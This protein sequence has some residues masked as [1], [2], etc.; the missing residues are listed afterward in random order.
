MHEASTRTSGT[1]RRKSW[2]QSSH[3]S[4]SL[5]AYQESKGHSSQ[6]RPLLRALS[7]P[8]CSFPCFGRRAPALSKTLVT[9]HREPYLKDWVLGRVQADAYLSKVVEPP[10]CLVYQHNTSFKGGAQGRGYKSPAVFC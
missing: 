6:C 10:I 5:I 4:K 8:T 3:T 9:F 2:S 7:S 1:H